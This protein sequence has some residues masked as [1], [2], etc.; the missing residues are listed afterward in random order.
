MCPANLYAQTA[1]ATRARTY[2]ASRTEKG[3][4]RPRRAMA[5]K[6]DQRFSTALIEIASVAKGF[7]VINREAGTR[8]RV[9]TPLN[10]ASGRRT[11]LDYRAL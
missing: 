2:I 9:L 4:R 11:T 7:P 8:T 3:L 1:A 10:T 6:L 5:L